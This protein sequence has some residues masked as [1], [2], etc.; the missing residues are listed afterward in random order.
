MS[1]SP[2][3]NAMLLSVAESRSSAA[4]INKSLGVC[5]LSHIEIQALI[6]KVRATAHKSMN[7]GAA[8]YVAEIEHLVADNDTLRSSLVAHKREI[9]VLRD[10]LD[11]QVLRVIDLGGTD[12]IMEHLKRVNAKFNAKADLAA[13][14]KHE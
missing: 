1:L 7:D 12:K 3:T 10:A 4:S 13:G 6:D 9:E 2:E 14:A 8:I 11:K 5:C